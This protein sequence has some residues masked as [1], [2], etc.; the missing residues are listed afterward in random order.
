[1]TK[2]S[3]NN[4]QNAIIGYM[5]FELNCGYHFWMLYKENVKLCSKFKL[6]NKLLAKLKELITIYGKKLY[7]T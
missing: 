7:Y 1:M 2:F 5:L 6:V 3:Y 4:I